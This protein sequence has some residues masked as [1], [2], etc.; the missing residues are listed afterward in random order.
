MLWAGRK[1]LMTQDGALFTSTE[2]REWMQRQH[3]MHAPK[4]LYQPKGVSARY[5][6]PERFDE[7]IFNYPHGQRLRLLFTGLTGTET[8][9]THTIADVF[10]NIHHKY[11]NARLSLWS[12]STDAQQILEAFPDS[13]RAAVDILSVSDELERIEQY[14]QHDIFVMP[15]F[16]ESMPLT[17]LEAMASAMPVVTTNHNGAQDVI[18]NGE[19]GLLIPNQSKLA[20]A[21]ALE[22]L[23]AQPELRKSLGLAAY[24]TASRCYTWRQVS[25][26][27][28]ENL[29]RI[30]HKKLPVPDW[31]MAGF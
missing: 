2:E 22:Q 6:F 4:A 19:N 7:T 17:V 31:M 18:I 26:I 16:N 29:Y 1:S 15:G 8:A 13:A 20:L 24:E 23:I 11:P 21:D 5:Y 12:A 27:F 3:P 25:D 14:Q 10:T 28:E 30:L 9:N